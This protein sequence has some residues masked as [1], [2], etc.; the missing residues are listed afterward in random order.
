MLCAYRNFLT[1]PEWT[2]MIANS[3]RCECDRY[4]LCPGSL[5]RKVT[6]DGASSYV[7]RVKTTSTQ[8]DKVT[9]R[10]VILKPGAFFSGIGIDSAALPPGTAFTVI[11]NTSSVPIS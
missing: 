11:E 1:N 10:G 6:F 5:K 9:A 3:Q 7:W 8:A 2:R 4:L